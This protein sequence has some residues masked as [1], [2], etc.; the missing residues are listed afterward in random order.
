MDDDIVKVNAALWGQKEGTGRKKIQAPQLIDR[1][2]KY[3]QQDYL[4]CASI[5]P[6]TNPIIN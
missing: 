5:N 4:H 1:E 2:I 6:D 3:L